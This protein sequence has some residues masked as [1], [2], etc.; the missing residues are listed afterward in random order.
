MASIINR[1]INLIANYVHCIGR[2]L[3]FYSL[4]FDNFIVLGDFQQGDF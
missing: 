2:R 3:D 4:K 1:N